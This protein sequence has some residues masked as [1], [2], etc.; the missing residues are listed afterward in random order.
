MMG[1]PTAP[2]R[3]AALREVPGGDMNGAVAA[4]QL[5]R[6]VAVEVTARLTDPAATAARFTAGGET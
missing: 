4:R 6:R 2:D 1:E 3:T 5:D